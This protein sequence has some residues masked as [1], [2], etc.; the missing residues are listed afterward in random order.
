MHK[1]MTDSL[2]VVTINRLA[3]SVAFDLSISSYIAGC[4][5]LGLISKYVRISMKAKKSI[6]SGHELILS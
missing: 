1:T 4:K 2:K 5:A 3:Q 6:F